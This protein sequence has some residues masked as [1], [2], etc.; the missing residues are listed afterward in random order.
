[1]VKLIYS[2]NHRHI[3]TFNRYL[4]IK[5]IHSK[6]FHG[7]FYFKALSLS[8]VN[9][10]VVVS[11]RG[12]RFHIDEFIMDSSKIHQKE[13]FR[14]LEKGG[15]SVD[16]A[17]ISK[18]E[19]H[20]A[21]LAFNHESYNRNTETGSF[22]LGNT[23][24]INSTSTSTLFGFNHSSAFSLVNLTLIDN[25]VENIIHGD[26]S[27]VHIQNVKMMGNRYKSGLSLSNCNLTLKDVHLEENFGQGHGK[28]LIYE[29]DCTTGKHMR[30]VDIENLYIQLS[31]HPDHDERSAILDIEINDSHLRIRNT[32][33]DIKH[34][35]HARVFA[36]HLKFATLSPFILQEKTEYGDPSAITLTCPQGYNPVN[37]NKLRKAFYTHRI[38]CVPCPKGSY[39][40]DR[41][42]NDI[43]YVDNEGYDTVT[44]NNGN[45]ALLVQGKPILGECLPC[46]PGGNCTNGIKSQGNYYGLEHVPY[47]NIGDADVVV[48]WQSFTSSELLKHCGCVS[49]E[50]LDTAPVECQ[51]AYH[52]GQLTGNEKNDDDDNVDCRTSI[53][54]KRVAT[55]LPCPPGI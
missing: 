12:S 3:G 15:L 14:V 55:F 47:V 7:L 38:E 2:K 40:L 13:M 28:G 4:K 49:E 25:R 43:R 6:F 50:N 39:T 16:K 42:S 29:S 34:M 36:I 24:I 23:I 9:N 20:Q 44:W 1:M 45:R 18:S 19:F 32:T 33:V 37:S 48:D 17:S 27:S 11:S 22:R 46:P 26:N 31:N 51:D 30:S 10:Q 54:K 8:V 35:D 41:G 53:N 52:Q 5:S 21:F